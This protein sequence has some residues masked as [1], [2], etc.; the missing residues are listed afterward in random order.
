MSTSLYRP[1]SDSEWMTEYAAEDMFRDMLDDVYGTVTIAGLDFSTS[2]VLSGADPIA[3]SEMFLDY[4][5]EWEQSEG[6]LRTRET[7]DGQPACWH[8]HPEGEVCEL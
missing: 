1:G 2:T 6:D 8:F 4:I 7:D 3:F 5:D